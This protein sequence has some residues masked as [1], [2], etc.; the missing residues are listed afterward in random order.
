MKICPGYKIDGNQIPF[1][2]QFHQI[3]QA[4]VLLLLS[5]FWQMAYRHFLFRNT[6]GVKLFLWK[7]SCWD[8]CI[9]IWKTRQFSLIF[10]SSIDD[11][12]TAINTSFFNCRVLNKGN[13]CPMKR[14]WRGSWTRIVIYI[15]HSSSCKHLISQF[16]R[17]YYSI[18]FKTATDT[19]R[20]IRRNSKKAVIWYAKTNIK[21]SVNKTTFSRFSMDLQCQING[22]WTFSRECDM[23][24]LHY[25]FI[26][27]SLY[28][29][30]YQKLW[31][32]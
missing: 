10:R 2:Y 27:A 3:L 30:E 26:S 21:E 29:V 17:A 31:N 32:G 6:R 25:F 8:S 20:N 4:F 7:W 28:T 23:T 13:S 11:I 22:Q 19:V 12:S 18:F 9:S 24:L 14:V 5:F 1:F 15:V 16:W